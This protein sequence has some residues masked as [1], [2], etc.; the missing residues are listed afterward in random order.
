M[1]GSKGRIGAGE[2]QVLC[3]GSTHQANYRAI[4]LGLARL[5]FIDR[6]AECFYE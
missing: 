5:D 1:P 2:G 3:I 4:L 6:I